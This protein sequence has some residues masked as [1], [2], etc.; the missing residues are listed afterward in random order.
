MRNG[1]HTPRHKQARQTRIIVPEQFQLEVG[2]GVIARKDLFERLLVYLQ[3]RRRCER[4]DSRQPRLLRQQRY[5]TLSHSE[6]TAGNRRSHTRSQHMKRSRWEERW[7]LGAGTTVAA[8]T[9][10][11]RGR[12]INS[13]SS[14]P[15]R[16]R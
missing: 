14:S 15:L 9:M 1:T 10:S 3:Q 16:A 2:G 4:N 8:G 13:R 5:L 6:A 7:C 11:E 12:R